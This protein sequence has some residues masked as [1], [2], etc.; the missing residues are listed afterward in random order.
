M[1]S[2]TRH[3]WPI[4]A[5]LIALSIVPLIAGS[6]RLS[7][8]AQGG[9]MTA[10]NMRFLGASL[11]TALHLV[12]VAF[13][14]VFGA[15]Q[16]SPGFRRS[17][18]GWHRYF[19]RILIPAG[20]AAALSG[21]WMTQFF[22]PAG[23]SGPLVADFDGPALYWIRLMVGSAMAAFLCL[24]FAA[25][26]RRD[27]PAHRGWMMRAYALGLGAGTQAF[28]HIPWFL[29]PAIRGEAA[30]TLCMGAGWAINLVVAE[31][32][33]RRMQSD[34]PALAVDADRTR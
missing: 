9:P 4:P 1:H 7:Q 23:G 27:V 33:I 8:L 14:S 6:L 34:A 32:F 24:G 29:F 13:Y 30:R 12:S 11:V 19:G 10:E 28:T 2:P 22:P 25:I 20:L 18:P 21:L 16:F 15:L 3:D 17:R 26:R 31:W 5:G